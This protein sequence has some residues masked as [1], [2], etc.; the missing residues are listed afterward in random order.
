MPETVPRIGEEKKRLPRQPGF[1][2]EALFL[3]D[4][5]I[6]GPAKEAQRAPAVEP[7]PPPKPVETESVAA[8]AAPKQGPKI[9]QADPKSR[10]RKQPNASA[11][12]TQRLIERDLAAFVRKDASG[13]TGGASPSLQ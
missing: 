2:D 8:A 11:V 6:P 12:A 13:A 1:S 7:S 10:A 4:A 3:S 5:P 9:A